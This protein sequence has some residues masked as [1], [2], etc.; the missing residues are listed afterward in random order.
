MVLV[1]DRPST[2]Y[3][4]TFIYNA[5]GVLDVEG[6]V[7]RETILD[8]GAAKVMLSKNFAAATNIRVADLEKGVEFVTASEA[9][10]H[11]MGVTK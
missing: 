5:N 8:T 9:V 6:Y 3:T 7:P 10:E 4:P 11:P 2:N 1:V